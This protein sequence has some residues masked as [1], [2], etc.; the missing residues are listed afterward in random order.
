[1]LLDRFAL[2]SDDVFVGVTDALALI[3]FRGIERAEFG[4]DFSDD[5][6]IRAFDGDFGIFVDGDFDLIRERI[7]DRM[8]V[9]EIEGDRFALNRR[10]ESDAVDLE[11]SDEP[12]TD[13]FDHVIHEGAGEAVH[14]LGFGVLAVAGE[15]DLVILDRGRGSFG[16]LDTD[17]A[18]F[19]FDLDLGRDGDGESS[20]SRHTS[21]M[22]YQT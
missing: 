3:R 9:P 16:A 4:G 7:H 13:A 10:F 15:F 19:E 5:L 14:G 21:V 18:A 11:F 17:I 8:G 12:I 2:F 1:V 6:F 22:V 20:D